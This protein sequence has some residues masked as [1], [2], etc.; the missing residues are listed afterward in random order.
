MIRLPSLVKEV[1]KKVE[2]LR[3][4]IAKL[5]KKPVGDP[6]LTVM[7]MVESFKRDVE[8][9]VKGRPE[10]GRDGLIQTLRRSKENFREA[11]FAQAPDFRPFSKPTNLIEIPL[12]T[13]ETAPQK[14][15]PGQATEEPLEPVRTKASVP[16]LYVDEVLNIAHEYV[17]H[18]HRMV[19]PRLTTRFQ[20]HY[21][22]T[23][24]PLP[25]RDLRTFYQ[26]HHGEVAYSCAQVLRGDEAPLYE[27]PQG[28][29]VTTLFEIFYGRSG[30]SYS[31]SNSGLVIIFCLI[32]CQTHCDGTIGE[33]QP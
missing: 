4:E 6:V 15:L 5:P 19:F 20:C 28:T 29:R 32:R 25:L 30:T 27:G 26:S 16:P 18:A 24:K 12:D 31:V 22:R 3:E 2:D 17:S 10:A 23:P 14:E 11:I 21:T 9:L 8:L 7:N 1:E 33:V 13:A